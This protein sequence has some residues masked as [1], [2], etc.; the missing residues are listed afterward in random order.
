MHA[1]L[2]ADT[3]IYRLHTVKFDTALH[4]PSPITELP[5]AYLQ[6]N[7]RNPPQSHLSERRKTVDLQIVSI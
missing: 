3:Q 2:M 7:A 1:S 6:H 5:R 4:R